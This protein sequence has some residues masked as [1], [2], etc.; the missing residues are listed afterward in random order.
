MS[1]LD[2]VVDELAAEDVT[3]LP[4]S[5]LATELVDLDRA[6]NRLAGERA[7]RLAAFDAAQGGQGDGAQTTAAWLGQ[8]CRIGGHE[9]RVAV[10]TA[11][12]LR[13]L[14]ATATAL[15][16]GE[17]GWAHASAVAPVLTE[18]RDRLGAAEGAAVEATLLD[19]ARS[20]TVDRMKIAVRRVR[21]AL[22]PDGALGRAERAF[23]GRW[24]STAVT[25][26]GLV[27]LQGVLDAEGGSVLLTALD[28]A[29]PAPG[30]GRTRAQARAD[31]LVD[32]AHRLLDT[33]ALPIV[34]GHRPH[35]TLTA[36]V[37]AL[38]RTG[39][40]AGAVPVASPATDAGAVPVASPATD[41]AARLA[42]P[43]TVR[44]AACGDLDWTGPVPVETARRIACDP[45]VTALLLDA[46]GSPLRAGRTQR[47]VT[48]AQRV[49]LAQRDGGCVHPGCRRPPAWCDAHH[50]RHWA[51]GGPTDLDNL[52][53]LCRY[54]HRLVHEHDHRIVRTAGGYTVEAPHTRRV[55]YC[56][57]R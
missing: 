37:D 6:L 31:A 45:T 33:G 34:A 1:N 56:R 12:Q 3:T 38:Q 24:L 5:V 15:A 28:A 57:R 47:L 4:T 26:E 40:G 53:L 55:P 18:A 49:A 32:L 48:R 22:D 23:T 11:V 36:A 20:D 42:I 41:P 19:L 39:T 8:R 10:R 9:A 7:R 29:M 52:C 21:H 51:D 27:H 16:A 30:D 13:D 17:I 43:A 25:G 46:G 35:L 2:S 54:H 14:P 50:V 44:G